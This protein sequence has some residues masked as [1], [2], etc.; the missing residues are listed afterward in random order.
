MKLIISIIMA[1][2]SLNILAQNLSSVPYYF[3]LPESAHLPLKVTDW[4][5]IPL[6]G[7]S[8]DNA[9]L[10]GYHFSDGTVK[11]R[12][13]AFKELVEKN[14][15]QTGD[16][17]L[18]FRP[19]WET[20]IPYSRIQMGV[21][22]A[23]VAY[24]DS[25]VIKNLDM[26]LDTEYNGNNLSSGFDS[27]HY[28]ETPHI[29]I[30]RPRNFSEEKKRNLLAWI[31]KLRQNYKDIRNGG[32]LR[33]NS[34]YS[35]PKFNVYSKDDAFVTTMAR[36]LLGKDKE[37]RDLTMFCSE[38]AWALLSLASC[39]PEDSEIADEIVS[40]ASCIK[41]IFDPMYM[42]DQEGIPGLT[43]GP[44]ATLN[45][46]DIS[47]SEKEDLLDTLFATGNM[48]T[49][50]SGHRALAKNPKVVA[51]IQALKGFY[52]AKLNRN[53]AMVAGITAQVNPV[54]GRNYSP[55]AF[56]I[57]SMLEDTDPGRQFDYVATIMF[58]M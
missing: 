37:S 14:I 12:K 57:N 28:L 39:D 42:L 53:E 45:S 32:L 7:V 49:L 58:G 18:S 19:E 25:G 11:G 43:E 41:P 38:Y 48:L 10:R 23:S 47:N 35:A 34:D 51:L 21:S 22:H 44:L 24:L 3:A 5:K 2:F 29:Q 6:A 56:L 8:T 54:G 16:I 4:K 52:I 9:Y 50:S 27:K 17:V 1:C 30:L 15:I 20:T 40:D 46:L 33:F 13:E 26:P 36:I 31:G 55:S